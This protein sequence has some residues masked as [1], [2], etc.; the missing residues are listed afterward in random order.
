MSYALIKTTHVTCAA[1]SLGLFLL[2]GVWMLHAPQRLRAL[3]VRVLPH[4][5]DTVLLGSAVTLAV[6]SRQYPL[7]LP[8]LTAK[9]AALLAYIGLG[10]VALKRGRTR[11]IRTA[12]WIA[13]L[14]VFGYIVAV[15]YTRN[16]WPVPAL[17]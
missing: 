16:P 7:E 1:L 8:W 13:A 2:R 4:V 17:I 5:V 12:A 10:T 11:A 9:I 15:A 14:C 3:W 6:L